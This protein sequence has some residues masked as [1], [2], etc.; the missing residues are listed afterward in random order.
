MGIR[1]RKLDSKI[2]L[3]MLVLGLMGMLVAM[4]TWAAFSDTTVNSGNT[5]TAGSVSITDNDS[6][7]ALYN[8]QTNAAPGASDNGCIKVTF[9]GSLDS[10]V[11]LYGSNN[12][13]ANNLDDQLTLEITS[14]SGN[15]TPSDCSAF[16]TS[17]TA[18]NIYSGSL[19]AFMSAR[20]SYANGLTLNAGGNAVWSSNETVTYRFVLTLADDADVNDANSGTA[21]GLSTGAHSFTWEARNN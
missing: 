12:L 14:G 4:A 2:G 8:A 6:D 3:T 19:A 21:S 18:G 7:V 16:T 1:S 5:F 17:E 9:D 11:K 10:T 20:N 13:N 15:A